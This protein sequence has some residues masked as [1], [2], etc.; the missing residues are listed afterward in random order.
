[1]GGEFTDFKFD[2]VEYSVVGIM[3]LLSLLVGVYYTFFDKQ[4][5]FADYML[6]GKTMSIFPVTMSLVAR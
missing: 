6:G 5:T 2:W 3:L 4:K 1:M